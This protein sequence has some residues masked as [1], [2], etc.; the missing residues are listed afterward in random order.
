ME[1]QLTVSTTLL[2]CLGGLT[3]KILCLL[4]VSSSG[5]NDHFIHVQV[6][7]VRK[8]RYK[9]HAEIMRSV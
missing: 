8:Q 4:F 9:L 1:I 7:A 2:P 3:S 6:S 5:D